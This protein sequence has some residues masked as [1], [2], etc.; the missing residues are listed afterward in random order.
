MAFLRVANSTFEQAFGTGAEDAGGSR[1]LRDGA[2][3]PGSF[4][5]LLREHL[6][7]RKE[8]TARAMYSWIRGGGGLCAFTCREDL[9]QPAID[10][11]MEKGR[12]F[13]LVKENAGNTGFLIRAADCSRVKADTDDLLRSRSRYCE[14]T[15]GEGAGIIY[16]RERVKDKS[17]LVISGLSGEAAFYLQEEARPVLPGIA[18]GVD[19]MPDG[20]YTITCHGESA[21]GPE[22]GC[23]GSALMEAVMVTGGECAGDIRK[24]EALRREYLK[25]K[26]AGFPDRM[27]TAEDPVWI[28]GNGDCYVKR[29]AEGFELGHAEEACGEVFLVIDMETAIREDGYESR[30]G[31]ALSRISGHI[32]LY[33]E[34]SVLEYFRNKK[35][36]YRSAKETGVKAL[37]NC[38]SGIVSEKEKSRGNSRNWTRRMEWYRDEMCSLLESAEKGIVPAGYRKNDILRLRRIIRAFSLD[39]EKAQP[40]IDRMRGISVHE[41]Q[42]GPGRFDMEQKLADING[43]STPAGRSGAERGRDQ[44]ETQR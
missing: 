38:A 18:V 43:R 22:S 5:A 26:V 25:E 42:A 36:H 21:F 39:M 2:G 40:A 41:R 44:K 17:M 6:R 32:C 24:R 31:S 30:L 4:M 8:W 10:M 7:G 28:V 16:R 27:G 1:P 11:L 3:L 19:R 15:T 33:E 13:V 9:V 35:G 12:P 14:I 29:T 37:V 34:G 23:F 20:T